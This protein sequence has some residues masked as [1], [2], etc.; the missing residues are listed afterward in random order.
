MNTMHS[1]SWIEAA[2]IGI[3]RAD[4]NGQCIYVNLKWC[5]ITGIS[6]E[7]ALGMGWAEAIHPDDRQKVFDNWSNFILEGTSFHYEYRF[8]T[9]SGVETWVLGQAA[10]EKNQK[11][12][13]QGYVGSIT[14][15]NDQKKLERSTTHDPLTNFP[16]RQL[17]VDRLGQAI[18]HA[19][20]DDY[21]VC[22]SVLDIDLF[23]KVN[24]SLGHEQ[25][26]NLLKMIAERLNHTIRQ[27][28]TICRLGG[29]E[30]SIIHPQFGNIESITQIM[31][32]LL[33]SFSEPFRLEGRDFFMTAS[34]GITIFPED[35]IDPDIL[36]KNADL[37]MSRA[38]DFGRSNFQFFTKSLDE[39][40]SKRLSIESDI[41]LGLKR[42]EFLLYHQPKVDL[43]TGRIT[44]M[45]SLVRW[46]QQGKKLISPIEFIPI[47]EETGLIVPLGDFILREACFQN[48][49]LQEI[50]PNL[51][52]AVNLSSRQFRQK[53]LINRLDA[54]LRES[55]LQPEKLEVE[56]TESMLVDNVEEAIVILRQIKDRGVTIAMDDFGT[57]Y[58]SLSVLKRFPIDT[59]KIDQSFVRD[60][61][62]DSDDAQ[63][64]SAIISMAHSLKL[65][66]V[67]EGVETKSS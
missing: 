25:G 3:L 52:V 31:Q 32:R 33:G 24:D 61:S 37:A 65:K 15:I 16:N 53:N 30:F 56:I 27:E 36:L 1:H 28:D 39:K 29:D 45:E 66:V 7:A 13:P 46:N 18:R 11:G 17:F 40:A 8:R 50:N 22:V 60:L 23:K 59:L 62:T 21:G 14:D 51:Q 2:P 4:V 26:D 42:G 19:D 55:G 57:G 54:A 6:K 58:S 34:I 20:R 48:S 38:K 49:D 12:E 41:R 9:K 63:I 67:A 35:G 5:E 43:A 47:A 44:G 64:V 10:I